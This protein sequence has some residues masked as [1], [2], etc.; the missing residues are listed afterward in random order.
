MVGENDIVMIAASIPMLRALWIK[1]KPG[2]SN[3]YPSNTARSGAIRSKMATQATATA[4]ANRHSL[5]D[6]EEHMLGDLPKNGI[7]R[8]VG[9]VQVV[10]ANYFPGKDEP[11]VNVRSVDNNNWSA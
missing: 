8:T 4:T 2:S 7:Q 3:P 5:S 1:E 10:E 11:D 6:D 9:T